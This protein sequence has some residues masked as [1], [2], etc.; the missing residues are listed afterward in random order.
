LPSALRV[1]T[2]YAPFFSEK[3]VVSPRGVEKLVPASFASRFSGFG[4]TS[5]AA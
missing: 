2:S 1:A 3:R 5:A 4:G